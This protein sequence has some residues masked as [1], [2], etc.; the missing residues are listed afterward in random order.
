VP[1]R[2]R[3]VLVS[4]L[5]GSKAA[6]GKLA[7]LPKVYKCDV[8][9]LAGDLT[10]KVLVPI[11]RVGS[12]YVTNLFGEKKV[13]AEGELNSVIRAIRDSGYYAQVMSKEEYD[14]LSNNPT[15]LKHLLIDIMVREF[16]GDISRIR[17]NYR[18]LGVK[19]LLIPGNDDFNDF[20]N[21]V[22]GIKDDTVMYFDEEVVELGG[23]IYA[24]FGYS[25]PTPWHTERELMED[26]IKRRLIN[27][28]GKLSRSELDR[29]VAV[30]HVPPYNTLIDQAPKLTSDLKPVVQGGI[31]V[32]EHV[33]SV[34]VREV[35]EDF[36]PL[37]SLH[38]HVHESPGIDYLN[39]R[40]CRRKVPVVN[41]GSEYQSGVLRLAYLII[42]NGKL[43][44]KLLLRG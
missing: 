6:Y 35:I 38:G 13:I 37:I 3:L 1:D 4:D 31:V 12:Q 30:I 5:H 17:D 36:G 42:E 10:G 27:I 33:G 29:T 16:S 11:I 9:V 8:V 26:E 15:K 2:V 24:G 19:L 23:L 28:L 43:K 41:A 7:N 25:N 22:R 40:C 18:Q 32:M 44:D 14:E 20:A 34:A 39:A 21:A